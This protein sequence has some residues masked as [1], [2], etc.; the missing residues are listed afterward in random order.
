MEGQGWGKEWRDEGGRKEWRDGRGLDRG[1][2]KLELYN[3]TR[4]GESVKFKPALRTK[5]Q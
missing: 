3:K 4:R 2:G 1:A 5:N